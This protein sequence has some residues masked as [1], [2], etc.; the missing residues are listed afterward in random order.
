VVRINRKRRL[1]RKVICKYHEICDRR[2]CYH[3]YPHDRSNKCDLTSC[4]VCVIYREP[5]ATK[6]YLER[7]GVE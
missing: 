1:A 7:L 6:N 2:N 4:G 5:D 3:I